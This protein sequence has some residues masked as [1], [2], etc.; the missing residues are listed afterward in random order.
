MLM[1]FIL[2]FTLFSNNP[3]S[4]DLIFENNQTIVKNPFTDGR[5]PFFRPLDALGYGGINSYSL[6]KFSLD[7]FRLTGVVWS[8]KNPIALFEGPDST[9]YKLYIGDRIGRNEGIITNIDN[10]QVKVQEII[11]GM[12]QETII[13]INKRG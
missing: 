4:D 7:E 2:I 6:E 3:D 12:Q 10:A 1:L 11:S 9:K 5:D 13:R 8:I